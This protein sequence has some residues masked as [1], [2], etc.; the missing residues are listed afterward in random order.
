[1]VSVFERQA[2]R[3]VANG[4]AAAAVHFCVLWLCLVPVQ[5]GSA[6]A[7][8]LIASLAGIAASFAGNRHFVFR[9]GGESMWAQLARFWMLY[10]ML[11]AM[12][13]LVL[14]GWTDLLGQDYR[15]GF[16]LGAGLQAVITYFGGKHWVFKA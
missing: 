7:A 2:V 10:A 8:N 14:L 15:I 5:L 16:L 1:M 12:H 13:G 4:L 6:G 11:S 9:A 3:F